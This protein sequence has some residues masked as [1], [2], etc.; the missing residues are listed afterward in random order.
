MLSGFK[1][2]IMQGNVIDL[3]VGV[4]IGAAFGALVKAFTDAFIKPLIG[5]ISGGGVSGGTFTISGQVF[6]YASFI[7]AV[8]TFA[9]TA[10]VVYFAIVMPMN[11][12]KDRRKA[13]QG[14]PTEVSNEE[15]MVELLE[16][17]ASK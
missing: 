9:L 13:G 3:A 16:R 6:D 4:V 14:E 7:N 2:F 5:L 17:I 10:A 15:R 11:A 12:L 1:K 8:I